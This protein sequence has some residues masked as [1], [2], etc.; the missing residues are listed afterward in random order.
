[1]KNLF[2]PFLFLLSLIVVVFLVCNSR[3]ITEK[4]VIQYHQSWLE[5]RQISLEPNHVFIQF[6]F[7]GSTGL[8][9]IVTK[10]TLTGKFYMLP[11]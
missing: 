5:E 6:A 1:M 8:T 3:K 4:E 7:Q 2:I 9:Y 11:Q 10:D